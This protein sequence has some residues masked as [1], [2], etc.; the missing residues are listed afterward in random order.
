MRV[1]PFNPY[2]PAHDA[3]FANRKLEQAMFARALRASTQSSLP[4]AWNVAVVGPWGIGKTS[5]LRRFAWMASQHEPPVGVVT[6]TAT[7][8][9]GSFDGFV[10][11]L[12]AR[13]K[14]DLLSNIRLGERFL[15]EFARWE[16]HLRLGPVSVAR[17]ASEKADLVHVDVLYSELSRLWQH[18]VRDRL[19]A[20]FIFIDDANNLLAI[21]PKFLLSLRAVFQD[22]QGKDMV[23][24]LVIT[25]QEDMFEATRDVS[26]PVTRF[27]ERLPIRPFSLDDTREA[28]VEPL[29]AVGHAL[30]VGE[31][32]IREIY[33]QTLGHPY[34]V[35][36]VMR[37]LVDRAELLEIRT[38]DEEFVRGQW[39]AVYER[40][41]MEKFE[42]EWNYATD[43]ERELLALVADERP[44]STYGRSASTLAARLVQK[45]LLIKEGRG[46]YRLYH[47]LFAAYV[48]RRL[49]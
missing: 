24:P 41:G 33:D 5:L 40:L 28:I 36:F 37:E 15:E 43:A 2:F 4:G 49:T 14:Q 34:F 31:D 3:L 7:T 21:D 45:G 16:P 29:Q 1:N 35:A 17:R 42:A 10:H 20:I 12:L 44:L 8:A 26:E 6:L 27:F 38:I 19:A 23:Y 18:Y 9:L 13:L 30:R 47:P 39:A 22:L 25:G 46:K 32:A 11:S 48:K